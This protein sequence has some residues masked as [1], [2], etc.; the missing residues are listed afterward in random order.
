V[1]VTG[2]GRLGGALALGLRRAG[3]TVHAL[4][5][6]EEGRARAASL[7]VPVADAR[8]LAAARL[9]LVTVQDAQVGARAA[10]VESRLSPRC[11]LVHC[12]GALPLAALGEAPEVTRHPRGSLH[13][14]CAVS[15][16]SASLAGFSAALS[17]TSPALLRTLRRVAE[18]LGLRPL[19]VP[20]GARAAYHAGAVLSAGGVVSLLAAAVAALGEAGLA[21]EE[22]VAALLPLARSALEGVA[23]RGLARGLTGPVARGDAGVVQAHLAALPPEVADAYR[24]VTAWSLRL[25]RLPP[26]R[27]EALGRLLRAPPAPAL[28][29]PAPAPRRRRTGR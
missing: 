26:E 1:L 7:G 10:A 20:E 5:A 2:L 3:W 14:L 11:A 18:D 21:E 19:A 27:G 15:D 22:A 25:A 8:A 24:A 12:A 17:A 23:Q 13:P 28:P 9:C 6:S 16:P 4:P 29:N